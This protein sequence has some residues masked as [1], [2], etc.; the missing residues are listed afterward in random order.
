L[1]QEPDKLRRLDRRARVVLTLFAHK[2]RIITQ[3]VAGALGLST[4]MARI[5]L[6]KW[7]NDGW[8]V[9]VDTS[10]KGRAYNLSAIY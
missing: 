6:K 4:R 8:L 2:D 5:L 10:N 7:A 9:V 1:P 3:D